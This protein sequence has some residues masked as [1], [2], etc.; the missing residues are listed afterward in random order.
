MIEVMIAT[1]IFALVMAFLV[2]LS[3]FVGKQYH[4]LSREAR[5]EMANRNAAEH[6]RHQLR[7]ARAGNSLSTVSNHK[8]KFKNPLF[9]NDSWYIYNA[10]VL[11]YYQNHGSSEPSL[12]V[13]PFRRFSGLS[14][15]TFDV[16]DFG[17]IV[18]VTV[19]S[20][21]DIFGGDKTIAVE[22]KFSVRPRN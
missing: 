18:E 5:A 15:V 2:Y 22:Q 14:D 17:S 16:P 20:E 11:R 4:V 12:N 8:L 9:A 7:M 19:D 10:G 13:V 6:I 21:T 1:A 3:F